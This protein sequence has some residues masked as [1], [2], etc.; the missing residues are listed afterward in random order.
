MA[1]YNSETCLDLIERKPYY[2]VFFSCRV[3]RGHELWPRFNHCTTCGHD[4]RLMK[5]ELARLSWPGLTWRWMLCNNTHVITIA[6]H[7][8]VCISTTRH[9]MQK[10]NYVIALLSLCACAHSATHSMIKT[11]MTR[12][13]DLH[14]MNKTH[15]M[16]FSFVDKVTED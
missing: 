15:H 6:C 16:T 5:F 10:Y 3:D 7:H 12:A 14:Y 11:H 1:C 4:S 9:N 2:G 8:W 13:H